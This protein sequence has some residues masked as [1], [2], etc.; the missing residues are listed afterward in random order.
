VLASRDHCRFGLEELPIEPVV[1][2]GVR[3][4]SLRSLAA[5]RLQALFGGGE[6]A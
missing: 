5:Q 4:A 2:E 3:G 1:V 6:I